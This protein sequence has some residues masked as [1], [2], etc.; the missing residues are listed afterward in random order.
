MV[1][2]GVYCVEGLS[3]LREHAGAVARVSN[4]RHA[5]A[6]APHVLFGRL[7]GAIHLDLIAAGLDAQPAGGV[8]TGLTCGCGGV[9]IGDVG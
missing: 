3:V 8:A 6:V 2:G 1:V 9:V 4:G 5:A 7:G